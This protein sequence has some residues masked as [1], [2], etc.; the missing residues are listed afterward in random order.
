MD[1][2]KSRQKCGQVSEN[3][4]EHGRLV[5]DILISLFKSRPNYLEYDIV[6]RDLMPDKKLPEN[7]KWSLHKSTCVDEVKIEL[8]P[9]LAQFRENVS[10]PAFRMLKSCL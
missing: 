8:G 10:F 7:Q 4:S 5:K 6:G 2:R 1:G 9:V 3:M